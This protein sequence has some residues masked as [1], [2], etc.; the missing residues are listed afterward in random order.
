MNTQ[1]VTISFVRNHKD[2]MLPSMAHSD[3]ACYDLFSVEEAKILPGCRV[4]DTG[5]SIGLPPGYVGLVCS[6]SGLASRG[7]FVAN[8]PGIIDAGYRG[9]LKVVLYNS[10][11]NDYTV[12]KGDRIGQLMIQKVLPSV[13][14]EVEEFWDETTRGS[15][16]FGS[17]GR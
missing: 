17:T 8:A 10:T 3:D 9:P 6:R 11:A 5:F 13:A 2:A 12:H 7:I 1:G 15:K 14:V 4:I 16:G